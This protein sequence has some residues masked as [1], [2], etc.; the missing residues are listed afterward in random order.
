MLHLHCGADLGECAALM[1]LGAALVTIGWTLG[2]LRGTSSALRRNEQLT[3]EKQ[4]LEWEVAGGVGGATHVLQKVDTGSHCTLG[5][6]Q[7]QKLTD[8]AVSRAHSCDHDDQASE[9]DGSPNDVYA[10]LEPRTETPAWNWSTRSSAP[11]AASLQTPLFVQIAAGTGPVVQR[12][13]G[14]QSAS[15]SNSVTSS[16]LRATPSLVASSFMETPSEAAKRG[17]P[18]APA[19][20]VADDMPFPTALPFKRRAGPVRLGI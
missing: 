3:A 20:P 19:M 7:D 8:E 1:C 14:P 4:R 15:S 13:P 10:R 12:P 18:F 2:N 17:P 11:A 6:L 5:A 16:V 9:N